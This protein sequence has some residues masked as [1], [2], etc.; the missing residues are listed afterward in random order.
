[1]HHA[2]TTAGVPATLASLWSAPDQSTKEIMVS[3]YKNL[4]QGKNKAQALQQAKLTYLNNAKNEKLQH[5]FYWAGFILSGA[6]API[7]YPGP[8]SKHPFFGISLFS[9]L[10]IVLIVSYVS[11]ARRV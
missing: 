5:P 3:F 4:K 1:M 8:F 6:D 2:F 9:L 11:Y 10:A 7:H